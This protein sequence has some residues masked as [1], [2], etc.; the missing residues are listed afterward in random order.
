MSV[1]E[2]PVGPQHPALHE[3]I[4]L[5][6]RLDGE[7][8]VGV[9]VVTGY[10][11]RGVE[12]LSESRSWVRNIYLFS[13]ICGI[14]NTVHQQAYVQGVEKLMGVEPPP[15]ANYIRTIMMELERIHSHMIICAIMAE[16]IGFD[17][18]F[19]LMMRDR[20]VVMGLKELIAG[21]RVHADIHIFG[22][23]KRDID[24]KIRDTVL[25]K[26]E[27]VEERI[28]YYRR[29][30]EEDF[31]IRKRLVDAGVIKY[32]E[33]IEYSLV[34]PTLRGSGVKSDV[35][36][37]DPYAAYAEIPFNVI[38]RDEGDSWARMLVRLDEALESVYM[39]R[40]ALE[41]LPGGPAVPKNIKRAAPPGEVFS[42]A[43]APRGELF[44][45]IISKGGQNPYRVKVRTPSFNNI[46]NG[47][48]AYRG[49]RLAD[50][51]VILTSFDPC[52]SCTE[53][54]LVVDES[55]GVKRYVRLKEL[56]RNQGW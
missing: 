52:I 15:R 1:I 19:M 44:Y 46:V 4:M 31:T 45:H 13:R 22:G 14:C 39:V 32:H 41:H 49:A 35:R 10:N 29:V 7:E 12:K 48:F 47:V 53:R 3:P 30:F 9:D 20:E 2:I 51:P 16:V 36:A 42:R 6:V 5:R 28:K 11:H 27:R 33:A 21:N 37:D 38:T 40:Y 18:L 55:R 56:S 24:D 26:L 54:V 23:V 25:R 17:S 43:E 34:G 8:V 50:V